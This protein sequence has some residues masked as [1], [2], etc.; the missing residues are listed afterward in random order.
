MRNIYSMSL[1]P[2]YAKDMK[3]WMR[4]AYDSHDLGDAVRRARKEVGFSQGE[5]A[6]RLAVTRMTVSR[7]ENGQAVS[8]ETALRAL[9]ECGYAVVVAPKFVQVR[10][11]DGPA[12]GSP[13]RAPVDQGRD[14]G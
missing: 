11:E 7:L 2:G 13:G 4:R 14:R 8:V 1:L 3:H 10:V 9:S 12:P 6:E 5:L